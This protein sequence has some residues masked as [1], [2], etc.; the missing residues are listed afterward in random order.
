MPG[1]HA[2]R[3]G[4]WLPVGEPESQPQKGEVSRSPRRRMAFRGSFESVTSR[5]MVKV[6]N[7]SCTGAMVEGE[8]LPPAGRDIFLTAAGHEFFGTVVWSRKGCCGIQFDEPLPPAE[9]LR[10]HQITPEWIRAE[11]LNAEAE[12]LKKLIAG[13]L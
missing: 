5:G 11:E 7:L 10:L 3:A 4:A 13:N 12:R 8:D 1:E 2:Y 9:V 6:R